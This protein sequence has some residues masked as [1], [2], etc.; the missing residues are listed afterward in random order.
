MKPADI[1]AALDAGERPAPGE[2]L[3]ALEAIFPLIGE[4]RSTP[5][6]PEWHGE[7]DVRTHTEMV[8]AELYQVLGDNALP[9][10][11]STPLILATALHDIGKALTTREEEIDGAMRITS[12]RHAGRGRSYVALRLG[13]LGLEA[14]ATQLVLA[15]IGHHH[16]PRKM[17]ARDHGRHRYWRL[18][19]VIDPRLI[20]LLEIADTRGRDAKD[21]PQEGL[22]TLE[23]FRIAAEEAEAWEVRDPYASWHGTISEQLAQCPTETSDYVFGEARRM[24]EN[25]EIFTPE[26][27][28]ARTYPHRDRHAELVVTCA[29]SGAGKSTWIDANL[30]DHRRVSLDEIREELTGR[31]D[32]MT[33]E[34]QVLQLAKERLRE[35]LRAKEKV[36]WDATGLREDGRA[37]VLGL[38]HDYHAHTRIVAFATPP[39]TLHRRNRKRQHMIP[40]AVIERQL[41]R[42][43]WPNAWEAH[44]LVTVSEG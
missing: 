29:P 20:Y 37:M 26:E 1:T 22:E 17:L 28:I 15:A 30:P 32:R 3:D 42:M 14:S 13:G 7:G 6:D 19:R 24:F 36:V 27:A 44:G 40:S 33:K 23:L 21:G 16:D 39:A 9:P 2:L 31:R 4:L 12:P 43:E 10:E 11:E 18:A 41:D 5:Q 25:G 34:G 8:I 38:G 35:S